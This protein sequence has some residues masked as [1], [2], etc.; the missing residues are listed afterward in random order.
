[1]EV[2]FAEGEAQPKTYTLRLTSAD[3]ATVTK[4]GLPF[5]DPDFKL[6][7]WFG[8]SGSDVKAAEFFVDEIQLERNP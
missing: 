5:R 3:G 6:C 7:T 1:V 4:T 2:E 8:F